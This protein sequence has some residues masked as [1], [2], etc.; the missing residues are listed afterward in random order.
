MIC[1]LLE[2]RPILHITQ[3]TL[4]FLLSTKTAGAIFLCC[5]RYDPRL[6]ETSVQRLAHIH[7]LFS[8]D[9]THNIRVEG[10]TFYMH[11]D[12]M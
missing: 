4:P 5:I 9:H 12:S 11:A 7:L 10:T 6:P 8:I 1:D 3:K 2:L